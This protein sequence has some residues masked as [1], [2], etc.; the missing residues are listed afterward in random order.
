MQR[1]GLDLLQ[2]DN[3]D[4]ILLSR[5]FD[6]SLAEEKKV[7]S[8]D[9]RSHRPDDHPPPGPM[10]IGALAAAAALKRQSP[11]SDEPAPPQGPMG[12]GALAAA[13]A[14][15]RQ[16]PQSDE[17]AP[18]PGPMGI[19]KLAAAAALKKQMAQSDEPA[20]PPGPMGIGALAAAAAMKK[21]SVQSDEPAPPG[22]MGIGAL[23]AAAALKKQSPQ[24]DEPAP[25]PGP[26]GIGALAA[27]AALKKQSK[28]GGV[29]EDS[30]MDEAVK[31]PAIKDDPRFSKVRSSLDFLSIS[32]SHSHITYCSVLPNAKNGE[33]LY[34]A[35]FIYTPI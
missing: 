19:G 4:S 31:E 34:H 28:D 26:M 7:D 30:S 23:A 27:A 11:Q 13:A 18:S 8:V 10:G 2:F 24:C 33:Y 5:G 9:E 29:Q 35:V 22:P 17:P 20:P 3:L 1:E 15:K 32:T 16:T 14:L 25:P 6:D 12:I 21:R